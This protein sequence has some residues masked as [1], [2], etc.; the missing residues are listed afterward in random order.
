MDDFP[1]LRARHID[2]VR[3]FTPEAVAR[4]SWGRERVRE[5][6]VRRLRRVLAH[7][8]RHSPFHAARQARV[9]AEAFQL[10]DLVELSSMTKDDV[11]DAWDQVVTDRELHLE[12]VTAHLD[13]LLSGEKQ[14]R[15]R[16]E[17]TDSPIIDAG[18]NPDAPGC[19]RIREIRGRSDA[20]FVYPGDI[21]IHPMSF[22]GVLGQDTHISEY[23]VQQ[24]PSG[25]R[26]L[27]IVHGSFSP[28]PLEKALV[29]ALAEA[30]L[31]GRWSRLNLSPNCRAIP[32]PTN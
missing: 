16:Y 17:L 14:T 8:Q 10:E 15:I 11:M 1:T 18:P 13:G 32:R 3:A 26:V 30:G 19:R 4:L 6:Q 22:R 21:R 20:W 2:S 5:E 31:Q 27:A 24:T 12:D 25:A 23:Q 28:G 7:A 29:D 9:D